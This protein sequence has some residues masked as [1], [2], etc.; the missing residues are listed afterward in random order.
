M[1]LQVNKIFKR[2]AYGHPFLLLLILT[3]QS[4]VA[5]FAWTDQVSND[6]K[7][8]F[9][10]Q[11]I[12]VE[13]LS[14]KQSEYR[15][16]EGCY[17]Y[18][19]SLKYTLD[20]FVLAEY[21]GVLDSLKV[22]NKRLNQFEDKGDVAAFCVGESFLHVGL[23]NMA[24]NNKVST[25][26]A[27]KKSY[28]IHYENVKNNPSFL[29][30]KKTLGAL[31]VA[32]NEAKYY[33]EFSGLITSV[34]SSQEEG[35]RLL[36]QVVTVSVDFSF[37]AKV[38]QIMLYQFVTYEFDRAVSAVK[39]LKKEYPNSD[40]VNQIAVI[41]YSKNNA[42][43]QAL[44]LLEGQK[45]QNPYFVYLKGVNY[46]QLLDH[47]KAYKYLKRFL[48]TNP[49]YYKTSSLYF[50]AECEYLSG[51]SIE[52][53]VLD[54]K[55]SEH[56]DLPADKK[57]KHI[58]EELPQRNKELLKGRLLFD[59]GDFERSLDVLN[60]LDKEV[61]SQTELIELYYRKGRCYQGLGKLDEA[62]SS[63]LLVLLKSNSNTRSYFAPYSCLQLGK[64][65]LK[66]NNFTKTEEYLSKGLKFKNYQHQSS[67]K[68]K[69]KKVQK[70]LAN[71]TFTE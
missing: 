45:Y 71:E 21:D 38:Y 47:K 23:I 55:N 67:I 8:I 1:F 37:E 34:K 10:N 58:V 11:S 42:S 20:Y 50:L 6:Y 17:E 33:S 44:K 5:Q 39:Q 16:S 61:L 7:M 14:L 35:S 40:L 26:L 48:E 46:L 62:K 12:T 15:H 53:A 49:S 18:L 68:V 56:E 9:S 51:N 31:D 69:L 41:L 36:D 13:V 27:L 22:I 70:Q 4:A 65:Y 60:Q 32:F 59:G 25:L 2:M 63:F 64:L 29:N 19:K 24:Q 3:A 54:V 66:E 57:A 30:S 28:S 52:K 43:Q